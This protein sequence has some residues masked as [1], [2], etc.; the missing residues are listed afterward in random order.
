MISKSMKAGETMKTPK[1]EMIEGIASPCRLL[2]FTV[3]LNPLDLAG[4]TG[5]KKEYPRTRP[6]N[7]HPQTARPT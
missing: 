7:N 2:F 1:I 3:L 4:P 5:S 6:P